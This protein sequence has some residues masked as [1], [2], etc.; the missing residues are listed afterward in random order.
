MVNSSEPSRGHAP[1]PLQHLLQL[2][3]GYI[4]AAALY[5]AVR[6]NVADQLAAG[7]KSAAQLAAATG[8]NEQALYR[9]LRLL[10]S[11]GVFAESAPQRFTLTPTSELL[12][13]GAPGCARD[14]VLF[15]PDPT[16]FRVYAEL[17]HAVTTGAP[18]AQATFGMP[19]FE[20]LARHP[21]YSE[22]FNR[23]MTALSAPNAG[24][25][26]QAYDFS[27]YGVVVDVGGGHGEILMSILRACPGV[28]GVLAEID[29]VAAGARARIASAGLAE[30]CQVVACDFFAAVP[31]GG[32]AYVMQHIIHDW[33]DARAAQI[34]RNIARAMGDRRGSVILLETVIEAGSEPDLGKFL[35]IEM[36]ALPGGRERS[37]EEFR[38]LLAASGFRLTG[39]V[40]TNSTVSV[41]EALR[42]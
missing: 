13:S 2:S 15:L 11:L 12:R 16:H 1:D 42:E 41:I 24:A 29:H 38:A 6:L 39:I 27:R 26:V 22:V 30:R 3:T 9:V 5:V 37:A 14:M 34:L 7:E 17:L 4:A 33:D 40:P 21:D 20:Y 25:V 28:R 32:D 31:P 23:A 36:L 19:V 10:A 35:D 18:A 8:A